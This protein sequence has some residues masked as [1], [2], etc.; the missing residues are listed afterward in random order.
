MWNVV[1]I[2]L[3]FVIHPIHSQAKSSHIMY[4]SLWEHKSLSCFPSLWQPPVVQIGDSSDHPKPTQ[5][6]LLTR[7][8][9]ISEMLAGINN[10]STPLHWPITTIHKNSNQPR[11]FEGINFASLQFQVHQPQTLISPRSHQ[12]VLLDAKRNLT[13]GNSSSFHQG[14]IQVASPPYSPHFKVNKKRGRKKK[15]SAVCKQCL[16]TQTP[17]WRCGP[18]GSRTLCNA[19]GLYYLKL[20][21]KFGSKEA[22]QIFGYKKRHNQVHVRVVPT[23]QEKHMFCSSR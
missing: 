10:Y 7:L 4:N 18:N 21:K 3:C 11:S 17:E 12:Y 19:C 5:M 1:L 9:S 6:K 23:S 14:E 22:G 13:Y 2:N 20:K 16:L 8:P 15:A